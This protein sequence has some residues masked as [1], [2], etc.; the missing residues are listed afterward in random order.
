MKII[1]LN[2]LFLHIRSYFLPRFPTGNLVCVHERTQESTKEHK[3]PE[4]AAHRIEVVRDLAKGR[5][6]DVRS[7]H[8]RQIASK[9]FVTIGTTAR[10]C[11]QRRRKCVSGLNKKVTDVE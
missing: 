3:R 11:D 5:R 9:S 8:S 4:V 2:N 7:V 6:R 10:S 1:F